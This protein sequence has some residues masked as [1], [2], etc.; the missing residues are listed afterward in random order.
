MTRSLQLYGKPRAKRTK[1][2]CPCGTGHQYAKGRCRRCYARAVAHG[3]I[4]TD[5]S[6]RPKREYAPDAHLDT[7]EPFVRPTLTLADIYGSKGET[8]GAC[9]AT[10]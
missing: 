1:L 2:P 10:A 8:W 7:P 6:Y 4:K 9:D 3:E 5:S